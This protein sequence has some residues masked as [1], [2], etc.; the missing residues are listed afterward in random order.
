MKYAL[1]VSQL[2]PSCSNS[3]PQTR[4]LDS[5]P[6]VGA[7]SFRLSNPAWITCSCASEGCL[8]LAEPSW[9]QPQ[10]RCNV[11]LDRPVG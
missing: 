7:R 8:C 4:M 6:L 9:P 5:L 2:D 3:D 1:S 11:V 10:P